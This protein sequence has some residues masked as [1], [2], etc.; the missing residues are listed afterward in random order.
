MDLY[1][2]FH[3]FIRSAP[4]IVEM[5]LQIVQLDSKINSGETAVE[6]ALNGGLKDCAR[7]L[8]QHGCDVNI[9]VFLFNNNNGS[10]S[11]N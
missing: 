1:N 2:I 3:G 11:F 10:I 9:Q 8:I 7:L 5:L 6:I 4:K